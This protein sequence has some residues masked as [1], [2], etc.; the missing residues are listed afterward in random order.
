MLPIINN[1]LPCISIVIPAYN[2]EGYLP[3]CIKSLELQDYKGKYEIIVVDNNSTDNTYSLAANFRVCVL[4]EDQHSPACARQK[5]TE[6]AEGEIIAFI[7]ADSRAPSNWLSYIASRFMWDDKLIALSGPYA[8]D[9]MGWFIKYTSLIGNYIGISLDHLFRKVIHKGGAIWGTNFAVRKIALMQIG[10]FSKEIEFYGEDYE[11]SLRLKSQGKIGLMPFLSVMTSARRLK[12]YGAIST[13]WNWVVCYFSV[14]FKNKPLPKR[15][16]NAP[17]KLQYYLMSKLDRVKTYFKVFFHGSRSKPAIALTFD[18]APNEPYTSRLLSILEEHQIKATF[19]IIGENA[20]IFPQSCKQIAARGHELGN[21]S[22]S[23]LRWLIFNRGNN[24]IAELNDTQ[25]IIQDISGVTPKFFR[26]PHGYF[27]PKLVKI[28][29]ELGYRV[30]LWD[31]MTSDWRVNI[32]ATNI[33]SQ[34]IRRVKPGSIIVLHD[35]RG[36]KHNYNREQMLAG[37]PCIIRNLK[38]KGYKFVT[39]RQLLE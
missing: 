14:L 30:V 7:D 17:L 31:V 25:K 10:G 13:Y 18:D 26:P 37:L 27:T 5:G 6:K 22:K 35:G 38:E 29:G 1:T 8:F 36:T 9:D 28:A 33:A 16:E 34:I 23:H 15:L 39:L 3:E 19:F 2:E 12:K 11:L 24:I 32:N 21:H 20:L 4:Q